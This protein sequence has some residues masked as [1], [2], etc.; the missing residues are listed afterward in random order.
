[1]KL[2]AAYDGSD[3]ATA[4]L[5]LAGA[6][7]PGA[8]TL[9]AHVRPEPLVLPDPALREGVERLR[10]EERERAA[11]LR[12]RGVDAAAAAGLSPV[13]V[14]LCA[15]SPWRALR[16]EAAE[17]EVDLV[18]CGTRGAGAVGRVLLGIDRLEPR[19]PRGPPAARRSGG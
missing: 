18:V 19:A 4:G 8:Q 12:A 16:A 15:S 9:V 2:L 14:D 17:R 13:A 7:F 3:A 6:L 10:D 5:R 1:M 11:E